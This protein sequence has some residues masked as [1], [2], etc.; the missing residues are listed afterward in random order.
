MCV[1]PRSFAWGNESP[2]RGKP[3]HSRLG[4][5]SAWGFCLDS[6]TKGK[7]PASWGDSGWD[8][9]EHGSTRP[10]IALRVNSTILRLRPALE[11]L[12][13]LL[14]AD[15]VTAQVPHR[16]QSLFWTCATCSSSPVQFALSACSAFVQPS[17]SWCPP[18]WPW[19]NAP[20]SEKLPDTLVRV[21]YSP[22]YLQTCCAL[23][24]TALESP[25]IQEAGELLRTGHF[26]SR[27]TV[28]APHFSQ[29]KMQSLCNG[30]RGPVVTPNST[31]SALPAHMPLQLPGVRCYPTSPP[32]T[33]HLGTGCSLCQECP[34]PGVPRAHPALPL[35]LNSN[36]IISMRQA[37]P[38]RPG[39]TA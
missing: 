23:Y 10:P 21:R 16:T 38:S 27:G 11:A 1:D 37:S 17:L 15:L 18:T 14:S 19:S 24:V 25:L 39:I 7:P 9:E 3:S 20:S 30:L 36:N 13:V 29:G 8:P 28:T 2:A 32:G 12:R 5:S 22:G 31:S 35:R 34:F 26:P 6:R 33:L 4:W